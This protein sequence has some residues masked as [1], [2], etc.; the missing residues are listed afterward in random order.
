MFDVPKMDCPSEE[1]MIRLALD[2]NESVRRLEFDLTARRLTITHRG[3]SE[4]LL[5][6][7]Q[8]LG[9]GARVLET[10]PIAEGS[11]HRSVFE[12]P[13]MD[14]PS[15]ERMIRMA[16]QGTQGVSDLTF[17]LGA[18]RL[19][20]LHDASAAAL[21]KRLEPLGYGARLIGSEAADSPAISSPADDTAEGKTLWL[22]LAINGAMF[23]I[24]VA[25]GIIAQSA[26][27]IADSL[28]MFADAAVYGLSL[29]A[30]GRAARSK[31]RAAHFSGGVQLLLA[32]GAFAEVL[33]RFVFGSAPEPAY[34][35]VVAAVALTANVTCL[36]LI[37][38]H[39]KGGVHM[40]AS[41]IFSTND[42]LANVGGDPERRFGGLDRVAL[43][44]LGYRGAHSR[45]RALRRLADSA[46]PLSKTQ[47]SD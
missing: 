44:G 43:R 42:V 14:C 7:L 36:Y 9:L 31:L 6:R 46:A 25:F 26:G 39:R 19:T 33:R 34:M 4:A 16:L 37:S 41:W 1:R 21:L 5:A 24:E 38:R 35:M 12:L 45:R 23:V 40:R 27:L 22:L 3:H 30:V 47:P 10:H 20:V 8:P 29:Y 15:E 2:G 17:D 13:K 32:L 11:T 28:D 18:R